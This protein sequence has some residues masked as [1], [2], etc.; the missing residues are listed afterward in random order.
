[1]SPVVLLLFA[2]APSTPLPIESTEQEVVRSQSVVSPSLNCPPDFIEID[3]GSV[4]LGET[5][6]KQ[7]AQYGPN[8]LIAQHLLD[9]KGY[10]IARWPAPGVRGASW[11]DDGL[12]AS[13]VELL[14]EE[15]ARFGVRLCSVSE[16]LF[17]SAG[18]DNARLPSTAHGSK[19]AAGCETNDQSPRPLG[20]FPDCASV[21]GVEDFRVRSSWARLDAQMAAA[22]SAQREALTPAAGG[23]AIWGGTPRPDTYYAPNNFGVHFHGDDPAAYLDDSVRFCADPGLMSSPQAAAYTAWVAVFAAAPRYAALVSDGPLEAPEP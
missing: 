5:D 9:L 19:A 20:S 2:C 4:E 21:F 10:C 22:L 14:E 15:I 7:L 8:D 13:V 3:G 16:L 6:A 18:P 17:A 11:P 23:L 12:S 1:M